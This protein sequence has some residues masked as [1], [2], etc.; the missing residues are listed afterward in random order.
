MIVEIL[1]QNLINVQL[2]DAII[3][4]LV[5]DLLQAHQLVGMRLHLMVLAA[6]A[7]WRWT[8]LG[9]ASHDTT[10]CHVTHH[11]TSTNLHSDW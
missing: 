9:P 2:A 6:P 5:T 7:C 11:V 10:T 4:V 3:L 1:I 8:G